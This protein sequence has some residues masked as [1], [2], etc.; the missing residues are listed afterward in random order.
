L[1]VAWLASRLIMVC[2]RFDAILYQ[3]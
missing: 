3:V 1:D 2:D